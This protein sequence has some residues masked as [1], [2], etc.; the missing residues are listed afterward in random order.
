M[1][2]KD[3]FTSP[4]NTREF[5]FER[6]DYFIYKNTCLLKLLKVRKT[7][8]ITNLQL[9]I[10]GLKLNPTKE[11]KIWAT[12]DFGV[13][14]EKFR[15]CLGLT[16]EEN[17]QIALEDMLYYNEANVSSQHYS[18]LKFEELH[19]SVMTS[20]LQIALSFRASTVPTFLEAE[21]VVYISDIHLERYGKDT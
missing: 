4:V 1:Q 13:L 8:E 16:P 17:D 6:K 7:R 15:D 9:V 10:N 11:D 18:K 14:R 3:Q 19:N 5:R 20:S 21:E 2:T 12:W